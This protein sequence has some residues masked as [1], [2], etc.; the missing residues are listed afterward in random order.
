M[1]VRTIK[2]NRLFWK[3]TAVFTGLLIVLGIVFVV[4]ASNFSRTYYTAAHQELY[5]DIARHL[6]TFTQPFKNGKPDTSVTHDIIH[7]T[8][9][10]NPSVEVYLLDTAG[11]IKDYVVPDKTVQI[12]QVNIAKVKQWISAGNM[13]RPMG[14]NPK[15]PGEPSIF[16]A[17]PV[18]EK[19]RLVGYVYAVLASEKQKAILQSLDNNLYLRLASYMFYAALTVAFIVGIVTFFL[20]TDSICHI[21]GVV[22]RFKEGDYTA[23]IEGYAKGNLGM[24]TST[25]NE[26]ADVIV[27]NIDKISATDKFR[28]ELIANVSHDLR[29]PLSIMQGYVETLMMKKDELVATDREKYLSIVYDSNRKLSVLVEQLFQYAKLE[30]NLITPQKESFMIADLAADIMMAYQLKADE[31]MIRLSIQAPDN[32][33]LVFADISLTERVLQ[34]LLDNAF[35]FTPAGGAITILLTET[36]A[37]VKVAVTDTGMGIS[38]EDLAHIFDRYKQIHSRLAETKGMGIGLAIVKK[39]LELHQAA[40]VVYSE[41]GKGTTFNFELQTL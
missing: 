11:N 5:G 34:N 28:Q 14:D 24:L 2:G 25:F 18:Y 35:K 21:A 9:V 30:A 32:L 17:A 31:K 23:R 39:I 40:I 26:M 1:S 8:M 12:H 22:R 20:I 27:D 41:P 13:H 4:I 38:P 33:P 19:G 36:Y 3:I 16:S 6:A 29:T 37:G 7:S 10:A 15:Q